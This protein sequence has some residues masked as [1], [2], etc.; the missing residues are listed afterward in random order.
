MRANELRSTGPHKQREP[1]LKKT[2]S[3][4]S[5]FFLK[6]INHVAQNDTVSSKHSNISPST[7]ERENQPS[8]NTN[9]RVAKNTISE[10][11]SNQ[12]SNDLDLN[13]FSIRCIKTTKKNPQI[14]HRIATIKERTF[15][16]PYS[17]TEN[18]SL[19]IA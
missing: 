5:R 18:P 8:R 19:P 3:K 9:A 17:C 13:S 15:T 10:I 4:P 6:K 7:M 2:D 14:D 11:A 12:R 1:A 16:L